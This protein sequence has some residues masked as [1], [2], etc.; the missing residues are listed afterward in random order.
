MGRSA[1]RLCVR[2]RVRLLRASDVLPASETIPNGSLGDA[3]ARRQLSTIA[4][5]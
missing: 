3:H 4:A 2:R 5:R 1:R